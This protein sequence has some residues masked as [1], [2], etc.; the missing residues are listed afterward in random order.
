M[1]RVTLDLP[2]QFFYVTDIT[3]GTDD[4]NAGGQVG[5]DQMIMLL[6]VARNRFF[7]SLDI[8]PIELG[9]ITMVAADLAATYR[10]ESFLGDVLQFELGFM[11]FN[12]YGVD[13]MFRVSKAGGELVVLAKT[14]FVF[15]NK[16]TKKVAAMPSLFINS[17]PL[18]YRP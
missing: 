10:S 2:E 8:N 16:K 18:K 5:N 13:M 15:I 4:I 6:S 1:A 17:I 3:V 7:D 12:K 11:D 14:G 9:D